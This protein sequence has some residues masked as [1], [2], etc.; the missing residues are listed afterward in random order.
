[1]HEIT[2]IGPGRIGGAIALAASAAGYR[3]ASIIYRSRG[4]A[5]KLASLLPG[6]PHLE[7]IT[8]LRHLESD[9]VLLTVSDDN[10]VSVAR[11]IA[12]KLVP[13]SSVYH[14][15]GSLSSDA[16]G[17]LR[18]QGCAIGSIHPLASVSSAGLGPERFRDAYF[19]VE[20]DA[21]AVRLGKVLV[22]DIGGHAFSIDPA[23]KA[24]YH[25]A[26]V[27]AA[28]HVTALFDL[29]VSLMIEAGLD[30]KR[31]TAVLRP[32]LAGAA[33]NLQHQDPVDA[34]TGP[35]ARADLS[36]FE[37]QL[38]VLR[39]AASKADLSIYLE[40]ASRSL[41]LAVKRGADEERVAQ[42]RKMISLAKRNTGC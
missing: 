4:R 7:S 12:S 41:D 14:T 8:K 32:L 35:F 26:A 34:L 5:Q 42:M 11:D 24:L 31:S 3:I 15:S 20:G 40:L 18:E 39:I 30:R 22:R 36:T 27:T 37:R 38:D 10:V 25:A 16:I 9:I 6:K 1:V 21:K 13:S 29:A 23:K 33:A 19:C 2:V 28:G 17:F